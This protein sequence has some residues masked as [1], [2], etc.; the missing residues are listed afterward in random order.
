[1]VLVSGF[2]S[3]WT[4]TGEAAAIIL[5]YEGCK[6]SVLELEVKEGARRGDTEER[7][8]KGGVSWESARLEVT[9]IIDLV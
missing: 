1:M 2:C 4:C 3:L 6:L 7:A 5:A 8:T 9:F